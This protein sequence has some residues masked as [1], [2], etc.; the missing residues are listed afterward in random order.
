MSFFTKNFTLKSNRNPLKG[1][2]IDSY[3]DPNCLIAKLPQPYRLISK[4]VDSVIDKAWNIIEPN[5]R[6]A[7]N[8]RE[9]DVVSSSSLKSIISLGKSNAYCSTIFGW[10]QY[11]CIG[12]EQG[13]VLIFETATQRC[14][15]KTQVFCDG[16]IVNQISCSLLNDRFVI[17]AAL[18]IPPNA[19]S[20]YD[21]SLMV[22][23]ETFKHPAAEICPPSIVLLCIPLFSTAAF[24]RGC[25]VG[26]FEIGDL[27]SSSEENVPDNFISLSLSP[28]SIRPLRIYLSLSIANGLRIFEIPLPN[29][30]QPL[31][32]ADVSADCTSSGYGEEPSHSFQPSTF[33]PS[34]SRVM[35]HLSTTQ[36]SRPSST[37][38]DS[39]SVSATSTPTFA[40][41]SNSSRI[42][43]SPGRPSFP[44]GSLPSSLSVVEEASQQ[45]QSFSRLSAA[46][47]SSAAMPLSPPASDASGASS[48]QIPGLVAVQSQPLLFLNGKS[49][50]DPID[51]SYLVLD[52][53]D[54]SDSMWSGKGKSS[55]L[56]A[57]NS[58]M[59]LNAGQESAAS[60][61]EKAKTGKGE[62]KNAG[63]GGPPGTPT[64][65]TKG[66]SST[67]SIPSSLQQ[68]QTSETFA[69]SSAASLLKPS[70]AVSPSFV[71]PQHPPSAIFL[72]A[73][74]P[75]LSPLKLS[76][77]PSAARDS[78]RMP[79]FLPSSLLLVRKG[80]NTVSRFS[81]K[82]R[83]ALSDSHPTAS[84]SPSPNP[85][86]T[87]PFTSQHSSL[88][89]TPSHTPDT[90][91]RYPSAVMSLGGCSGDVRACSTSDGYGTHCAVGFN[92]GSVAL[93]SFRGEPVILHPATSLSLPPLPLLHVATSFPVVCTVPVLAPIPDKTSGLS[94]DVTKSIPGA[95]S[96]ASLI[97]SLKTGTA[98]TNLRGTQL[99]G[100]T[101]TTQGSMQ[102][103]RQT[104]TAADTKTMT[105]IKNS[106]LK[107]AKMNYSTT[108]SKADPKTTTSTSEDMIKTS[109][110]SSQ[111][112]FAT[113]IRIRVAA[114]D[115]EGRLYLFE[116]SIDPATHTTVNATHP[117]T[118]LFG[119]TVQGRLGVGGAQRRRARYDASVKHCP[120]PTLSEQKSSMA[121]S[122]P[123]SVIPQVAQLHVVSLKER[124]MIGQ[125]DA[126]PHCCFGCIVRDDS[127]MIRVF[128]ATCSHERKSG[129]RAGSSLGC[130][131][132]LNQRG[133]MQSEGGCRLGQLNQTQSSFSTITG[134]KAQ[135]AETIGIEL[136]SRI[137]DDG[138]KYPLSVFGDCITTISPNPNPPPPTPPPVD[139]AS[140]LADVVNIQISISEDGAPEQNAEVE[141][142]EKEKPKEVEKPKLKV[143]GSESRRGSA[144]TPPVSGRRKGVKQS[145]KEVRESQASE[146][147]NESEAEAEAEKEREAERKRM[148]EKRKEIIQAMYSKRGEK[149]LLEIYSFTS[150]L[151]DVLAKQH[152]EEDEQATVFD[153]TDSNL[154]DTLGSTHHRFLPPSL[155]LSGSETGSAE[156]STVVSVLP[157]QDVNENICRL[158]TAE[159]ARRSSTRAERERRV[160]AL[161]GKAN[162]VPASTTALHRDSSA[163]QRTG[164]LTSKRGALL[165]STK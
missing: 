61:K 96:S 31:I 143:K 68:S 14:V 107:T 123:P 77:S 33:S 104:R 19:N 60:E 67:A 165:K 49:S 118:A 34:H 11:I 115:S 55:S 72:S 82:S 20:D 129:S 40:S 32:V 95:S 43:S 109:D 138:L 111:K 162:S 108:L 62:S 36:Q 160:S 64:R 88:S 153:E 6:F 120:V 9:E 51:G 37:L 158:T 122:L 121:A 30:L 131:T 69:F 57:Q 65:K 136:I 126:T 99:L 114:T 154:F 119:S 52:V 28:I 102:N 54:D 27:R 101:K 157:S 146:I 128:R 35:S 98:T 113:L 159:Q 4:L 8:V 161:I 141:E 147:A 110:I 66:Q 18:G 140:S 133:D 90:L 103:T 78:S 15:S 155:N 149:G 7:E 152:A 135:A 48:M 100:Q 46:T 156:P 12:T 75:A 134:Q 71:P 81:L 63:A 116:V 106:A 76:S 92:D 21:L 45:P 97:P 73:P 130:R 70:W 3:I 144:R 29:T 79:Y 24:L 148:E 117:P 5:I 25:A 53:A 23:C 2:D 127:G 105:N 91:W 163:T 26:L 84:S 41:P 139:E 56:P 83:G 124:D 89:F 39:P 59:Q 142:A 58:A 1:T 150:I 47:A 13:E 74:N 145:E 17:V 42:T 125:T 94:A 44:P 10:G 112:G 164:L 93:F 137:T 38:F 16:K 22:S 80:K 87:S 151:N 132:G 50:L 85:S 86:L